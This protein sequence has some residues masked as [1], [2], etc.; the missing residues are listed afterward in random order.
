MSPLKYD[1][2][3]GQ[4]MFIWKTDRRST[5]TCRKLT[6]RLVDGTDHGPYFNFGK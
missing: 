2:S 5:G 6:V 3:S 4:Y 1:A